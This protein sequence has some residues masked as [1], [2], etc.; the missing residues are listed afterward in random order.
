MISDNVI[1]S[2]TLPDASFR[3]IRRYMRAEDTD[4]VNSLIEECLKEA[5]KV[6][7][8]QVCFCTA[9]VKIADPLVI[10]DTFTLNS[11]NLCTCLKNSEKIILLAATVGMPFDRLIAK[12]SVLMPSKAL[13]MHA[14]GSERIEALCDAFCNDKKIS[15]IMPDGILT[16]RFSPGYGDLSLETQKIFDSVL[17]LNKSL[18]IS[19]N[20]ELLMTPSKSVTAIIGMRKNVNQ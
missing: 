4:E 8:P 11:K 19:F 7:W 20:D 18:G 13:C 12:Y 14:V 3:E 1:S 2:Y 5:E 10:A 15:E 17:K 6:L 9:D 16:P